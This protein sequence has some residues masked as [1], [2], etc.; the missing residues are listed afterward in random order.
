[1]IGF[2]QSKLSTA[3]PAV[4]L[5]A[6]WK[7]ERLISASLLNGPLQLNVILSRTPVYLHAVVATDAMQN[8]I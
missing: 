4:L 2:D 6:D 8:I 5:V 1:M 7:A 3:F